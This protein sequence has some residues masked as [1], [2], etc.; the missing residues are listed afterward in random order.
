MAATWNHVYENRY[1]TERAPFSMTNGS[2]NLLSTLTVDQTQSPAD[3]TDGGYGWKDLAPV[4]IND[5]TLTVTLGASSTNH[6][7]V[8]DAIRIELNESLAPSLF[9]LVDSESES[10]G[11][12][13]GTVVRTGDTSSEATV[14]LT[15]SN[16]AAATVEAS[17]TFAIGESTKSFTITPTDDSSP[18]G[19]QQSTI[20]ATAAS[21][22][23]GTAVLNVEDDDA[24]E[25]AIMD[26]TDSG[27]TSN[28]FRDNA[29]KRVSEAYGGNNQS[30]KGGEPG[31][32][33]SWTFTGLTDGVYHVSAT[34]N[35]QYNNNYNATD[36]QY[37]ITNATDE[38]IGSAV[39][40]QTNVPSEFLDNGIAWG[41]LD[42]VTVTGGELIVTVSGGSNPNRHT[43]AD[44]VRIARVAQLGGSS[45][46][47]A[48]NDPFDGSLM[49]PLEDSLDDLASEWSGVS[50]EEDRLIWGE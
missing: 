8:A 5:G 36:A 46:R 48:E 23:A 13:T 31:E 4:Y 14:S 2:G 50:E 44:A 17:I 42:T 12:A 30:L 19:I 45:L 22:A 24:L 49:D 41:T 27:Y 39:I 28:G 25:V 38:A 9:V 26:N 43:V 34:W 7:A 6:Y 32:E 3:F 40:N 15:S 37:S 33:A 18:D 47:M 29:N 16:S 21:Y 1:N 10:A 20:E 11:S 35:H